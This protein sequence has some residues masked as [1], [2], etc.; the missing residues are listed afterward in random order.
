M[1]FE[2]CC[3][4]LVNCSKETSRANSMK[5]FVISMYSSSFELHFEVS[6]LPSLESFANARISPRISL[7]VVINTCTVLSQLKPKCFHTEQTAE[8]L[9]SNHFI[10]KNFCCC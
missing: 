4:S 1:A 10:N 2:M 9:A 5:W 3:A 7:C 6:F 8:R